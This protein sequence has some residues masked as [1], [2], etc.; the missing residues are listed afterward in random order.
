MV[1]YKTL[2]EKTEESRS[3]CFFKGGGVFAIKNPSVRRSEAESECRMT[4][5]IAHLEGLYRVRSTCERSTAYAPLKAARVGEVVC[6]G[7]GLVGECVGEVVG[8]CSIRSS[9]YIS[10]YTA[11]LRNCVRISLRRRR[12]LR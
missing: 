4:T 5:R 7:Q 11:T 9:E 1:L 10:I 8:G 3:I 2:R 12:K 6:G